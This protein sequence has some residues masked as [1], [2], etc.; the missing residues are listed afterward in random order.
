MELKVNLGNE[1]SP[2][3]IKNLETTIPVY[4]MVMVDHE[5]PQ[6]YLGECIMYKKENNEVEAKCEISHTS[7][8][9]KTEDLQDNLN[10]D[11]SGTVLKR[12]EN[13]DITSFEIKAGFLTFKDD[14]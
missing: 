3:V 4:K 10:I 5:F 1:L 8:T 14:I 9:D 7:L 2:D 6:N 13:G 12:N 11:I